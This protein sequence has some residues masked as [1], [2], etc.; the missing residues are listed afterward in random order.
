MRYWYKKNKMQ[1]LRGFC[2]VMEEGSILQ[3]CKKLNI[4]Q[5]SVSLQISSLERD[6]GIPL[7]RR[8]N[9]R[10]IPTEEANKFYKICKKFVTE[11]DFMFE[12]ASQM[13]KEDYDNKIKIAAHSYML[14]HILPSY[15]KKVIEKNKEVQFE[16]HN[17]SY[18]EGIELLQ[19]GN[20]DF[21]I[22]PAI[23]DKL[24]TGI[25]MKEFYKCTFGIGMV[26]EHPLACIKAED[27]TWN[28]LA[29][30]DYITLGSNITA[31]G[32]RSTL[33]TNGV[34]SRFKLYNG[35]WEI[36]TGLIREGLSIGGSDSKYASWH[37]Y[38][39][40]KLCPHLMPEYKFHILTNKAFQISK[41]A[42]LLLEILN[43]N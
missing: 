36:C 11:M 5:S 28:M 34:D 38:G 1:L 14:S 17:I 22:Y 16:L 15:F 18:D 27:I 10:L 3:A 24:P 6:L 37:D 33:I 41:T 13:I 2:S 23:I 39:V 9:Q 20:L 31:Q 26:K 30:Y 25:D 40:F 19:A 43:P 32:L 12:N 21:A 42:K 7:F 4:A 8:E 29:Q 35:T